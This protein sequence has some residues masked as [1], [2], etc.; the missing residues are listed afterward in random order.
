MLMQHSV[1]TE[2]TVEGMRGLVEAGVLT[3]LV[4]SVEHWKKRSVMDLKASHLLCSK[5]QAQSG[6]ESTL[7]LH[8]L[9]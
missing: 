5:M 1:P 8:C 7:E 4:V 6:G 2:V 9:E 3:H